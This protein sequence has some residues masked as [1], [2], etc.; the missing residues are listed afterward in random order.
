MTTPVDMPRAEPAAGPPDLLQILLDQAAE[1]DGEFID[2]LLATDAFGDLDK[3]EAKTLLEDPD[4]LA[5]WAEELPEGGKLLPLVLAALAEKQADG[6]ALE[7]RSGRGAEA[8][9]AGEIP[10]LPLW[11]LHDLIPRDEDPAELLNLL[12]T[13]GRMLDPVGAGEGLRDAVADAMKGRTATS[14]ERAEAL[15]QQTLAQ[16]KGEREGEGRNPA[17]PQAQAR[18]DAGIGFSGLLAAGESNGTSRPGAQPIQ[19]ALPGF[20]LATPAN[21]PGFGR[22]LGE[23]M[24]MMIQQQI[25]QARIRLDPPGLGPLDINIATQDERTTIQITAQQASAREAVE[26]ELP[27]LRQM[28][29]EQGQGEVDVDVSE[30]QDEGFWAQGQAAG[31]LNAGGPGDPEAGD[32]A[33]ADAPAQRLQPQGLVDHYA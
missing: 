3:A 29:A 18:A 21:Q 11:A 5:G 12:Q 16:E 25:Q 8:R 19:Q 28:L 2:A 17:Q 32:G 10:A 7:A 6:E 31:L 26:S 27:R 22:A 1:G 14:T 30:R 24:V 23:R 4:R 33:A 15:L 20:Q 13:T 9:R